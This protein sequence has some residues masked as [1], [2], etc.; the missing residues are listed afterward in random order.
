MKQVSV[1]ELVKRAK[2]EDRSLREYAR[3]LGGDAAILSKMIN[4]TYIPKKPGIYEALTGPQAAPRGGVTAREL[5]AAA[6]RRVQNKGPR[7]ELMTR[8]IEKAGQADARMHPTVPLCPCFRGFPAQKREKVP[9]PLYHG[10]GTNVCK[11][12]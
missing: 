9:K 6:G 4:G 7:S 8:R 11:N 10:L 3:D 5:I 2:G 12:A 1:G